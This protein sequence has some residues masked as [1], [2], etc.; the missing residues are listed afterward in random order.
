TQGR[1][2][3]AYHALTMAAAATMITLMTTHTTPIP[4]AGAGGPIDHM[5][6]MA[7]PMPAAHH[8]T[9]T[10]HTTTHTMT[11]PDTT[12]ITA[13]GHTP[14]LLLTLTFTAAAATFLAL[15]L[16]HQRTTK[17]TTHQSA[18]QGTH[19]RTTRTDHALETLS[20]TTMALMFAT[21]TA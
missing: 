2:K 11:A 1:I 5:A 14:A 17:T 9:T 18:H 12:A 19:Q 21:M 20:A 15:L 13:L 6:A 16:R 10:A 8:T 4:T 7:M 3:C